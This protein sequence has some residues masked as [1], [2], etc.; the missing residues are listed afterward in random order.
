VGGYL[1]GTLGRIPL[2]DEEIK[3]GDLTF[4]IFDK[5]GPRL[6]KIKVIRETKT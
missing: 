5:V 4:V 6:K 1:T 3:L 2:L